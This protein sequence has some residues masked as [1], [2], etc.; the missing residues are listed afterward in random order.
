MV[1]QDSDVSFTVPFG[2]RTEGDVKIDQWTL[3]AHRELPSWGSSTIPFGGAFVG[4]TRG[5]SSD[6]D[7][8]SSR[9][10]LGFQG[11]VNALPENRPLGLRFES[12]AYFT[13]AGQGGAGIGCGVG[14]CSYGF[15][16]RAFVQVDF[17]VGIVFA[18]GDRSRR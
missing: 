15:G 17:L 13:L 6:G 18:F 9:F 5:T 8:S 1:R 4:L 2:D 10:T 12:R 14:G 16:S 11:G 7:G 3:G